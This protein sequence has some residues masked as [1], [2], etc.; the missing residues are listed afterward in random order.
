ML[1]EAHIPAFLFNIDQP[2]AV[3]IDYATLGYQATQKLVELGHTDIGCLLSEGTRTQAFLAGYQQCLFDNHIPLREEFVFRGI[4][5]SLLQKI[6]AHAVSGIV[7]SHYAAATALFDAIT[8]LHYQLPYDLSLIT[9]VSYTH[10]TEV[11][12]NEGE[13]L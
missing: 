5:D 3:N 9:P 4:T 2:Q 6:S 10:L 1:E 7:N 8:V 12:P 11:T 13:T